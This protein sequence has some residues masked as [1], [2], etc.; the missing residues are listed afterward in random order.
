MDD[1][2]NCCCGEWDEYPD[3]SFY[4]SL[5]D[6]VVTVRL[7]LNNE[8]NEQAAPPSNQEKFA[9]PLFPVFSQPS[10]NFFPQD[11]DNDEKEI[12]G[13][14]FSRHTECIQMDKFNDTHCELYNG[15]QCEKPEEII[16]VGPP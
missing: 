2:G 1:L 14:H 16:N 13:R 4:H 12:G 15:P 7:K 9:F 6:G 3:A 11:V 5:R 10:V 8:H